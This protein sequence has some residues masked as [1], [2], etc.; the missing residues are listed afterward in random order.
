MCNSP[1]DLDFGCYATLPG[2]Y[3]ATVVVKGR[4]YNLDWSPYIQSSALE[5]LYGILQLEN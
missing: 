4:F 3:V 2:Q 1:V 5:L